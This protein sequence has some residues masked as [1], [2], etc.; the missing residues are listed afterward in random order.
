MLALGGKPSLLT[1][2]YTAR[3]VS[4]AM[5]RA[6]VVGPVWLLGLVDW[7][8][9]GAIIAKAFVDQL[10]GFG[11]EVGGFELLVRP[12]LFVKATARVEGL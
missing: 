11:V 2:E 9:A 1:S 12:E 7:D 4:A 6:R 5:A 10:R 8:P 3:P